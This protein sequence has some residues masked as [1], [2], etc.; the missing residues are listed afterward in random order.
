MLAEP[1]QCLMQTQHFH[2]PMENGYIH[3]IFTLR[4]AHRKGFNLSK[5]TLSPISLQAQTAI[6]TTC[7]KISSNSQYETEKAHVIPFL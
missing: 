1:L 4:E 6:L 5:M 3:C 7:V 2:L